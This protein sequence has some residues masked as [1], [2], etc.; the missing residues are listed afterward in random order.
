MTIQEACS[1]IHSMNAASLP[2]KQARPFKAMQFTFTQEEPQGARVCYSV[3]NGL[4]KMV[5]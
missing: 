3:L 2:R 5:E 4:T 1:G